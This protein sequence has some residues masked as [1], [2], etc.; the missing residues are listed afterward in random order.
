MR[1]HNSAIEREVTFGERQEDGVVSQWRKLSEF[2]QRSA[3]VVKSA[4]YHDFDRVIFDRQGILVCYLEVKVR[5]TPLALYGDAIFPT[6]KHV[7]GK[8]LKDL[9]L[10]F[11]A[12]VRYGCGTLVEVDLASTPASRRDVTRRDR[13]GGPVPHVVYSGD[14]L[15][16][17]KEGDGP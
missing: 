7:F 15:T 14:Q 9:G 8:R 17:L 16:I 2:A 4:E 6:R 13:D 12:V 11:I 3:Y 5:R 1:V 10:P